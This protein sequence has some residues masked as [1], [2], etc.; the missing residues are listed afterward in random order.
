MKLFL[1]LRS[2][3]N[4][5]C[6]ECPLLIFFSIFQEK[7]DEC[8]SQ[9]QYKIDSLSM[10]LKAKND[11]ISQLE[12]KL[13]LEKNTANSPKVIDDD[14]VEELKLKLKEKDDRIREL[15]VSFLFQRLF[16]ICY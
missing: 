12:M 7:N 1:I 14:K 15:E 10:Q 8:L 5:S 9:L 2:R 3:V 11:L 13:R 6:F 4:I 16:N